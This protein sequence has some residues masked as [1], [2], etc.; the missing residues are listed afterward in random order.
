[1]FHLK[2]F[3]I[4]IILTN[5]NHVLIKAHSYSEIPNQKSLCSIK[6]ARYLNEY[7]YSSLT[8]GGRFTIKVFTNVIDSV[9]MHSPLQS[10][11]ILEPSNYNNRTYYY[12]S[13][14]YHSKDHLCAKNDLEDK[15]GFRRIVHLNPES[16]KT[17]ECLWRFE[18]LI[19]NNKSTI[20]IWNRK[21]NKALYA[22]SFLFKT[23]KSNRRNVYL[24]AGKPDSDQFDWE[25]NCNVEDFIQY[26][27]I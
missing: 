12:I 13:N 26:L 3:L 7:L 27:K 8:M 1:M 25:V 21:Y 19:N 15:L 2:I 24:W 23:A 16:R 14:F 5:L 17:S 20:H 18:H 10:L 22:A 4:F 6:N 11:W 9:Y